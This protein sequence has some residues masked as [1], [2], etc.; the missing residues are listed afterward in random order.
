VCII[1]IIQCTLVNTQPSQ[2]IKLHY[3][4]TNSQTAYTTVRSSDQS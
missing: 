1:I 3:Y 4:I 2:S